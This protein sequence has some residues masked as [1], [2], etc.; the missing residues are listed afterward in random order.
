MRVKL[1]IPNRGKFHFGDT[2]GSLKRNFSSDQLVSALAN[3]LGIM[4][5]ESTIHEFFQ[6]LKEGRIKFSS[7]FYGLDLARK[8]ENTSVQTIYFLPRPKIDIFPET[9]EYVFFHKKLKKIQFVSERLYLKLSKS[10]KE[11]ERGSLL[12]LEDIVILNQ[13]MAALKEELANLSINEEEL[14]NLSMFHKNIHPGV[15]INRKNSRSDNHF[16]REELEIVFGETKDYFVKP[17][18][19]FLV[20]GSLTEQ[21]QAAIHFLVDEGIGGKRSSGK[22]FFQAAKI[23]KTPKPEFEGKMHMNLSILFPKKEEVRYLNAYELEQ[24]NGYVY[25]FGGKRVRKKSTMVISEGSILSKPVEGS[26]MDV[27]PERF[28]HA[29]YLYGKPI[30]IGFGGESNG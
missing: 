30:F 8:T 7:L 24:R 19:Y 5:G 6:D 2:N 27:R 4:F 16:S 14:E 13:S 10:W 12:N 26:L 28:P 23:E 17:F 18:M 21:V 25:S 9:R 1:L 15:E 29:T 11:E 20:D 22:G 3:H